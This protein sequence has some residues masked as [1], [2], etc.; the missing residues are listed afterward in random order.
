MSTP[1]EMLDQFARA[2]AAANAVTNDPT[3][4]QVAP[5]STPLSPPT[6]SAGGEIPADAQ[7]TPG[8]G[9]GQGLPG[10]I[11]Q[12][13]QDIPSIV[14]HGLADAANQASKAHLDMIDWLDAHGI[15]KKTDP[16]NPNLN[17]PSGLTEAMIRSRMSEQEKADRIKGQQETKDRTQK[18]QLIPDSYLPKRPQTGAGEMISGIISFTT[19]LVATGAV[20]PEVEGGAIAKA[21]YG[22][23]KG[24]VAQWFTS[25][26]NGRRLA[27]IIGDNLPFAKVVTDYLSSKPGD[28]E[29]EK[30]MKASVEGMGLGLAQEA[31]VAGLKYAKINRLW[32]DAAGPAKDA[33]N[34]ERQKAITAIQDALKKQG[35][36][37]THQNVDGSWTVKAIE[38]PKPKMVKKT[39]IGPDGKPQVVNAVDNGT[40]LKNPVTAT[41]DATDARP[42]VKNGGGPI[43]DAERR[44]AGTPK[45]TIFRS[46]DGEII[47]N[48]RVQ[49]DRRNYVRGP[50]AQAP[51]DATKWVTNTEGKRVEISAPNEPTSHPVTLTESEQFPYTYDIV[52]PKDGSIGKINTAP[53]PDGGNAIR[54]GSV[55]LSNNAYKGQGFGSSAYQQLADDVLSKGKTL[56][57]DTLVS[58][59]AAHMYESL[60]RKGYKVEKNPDAVQNDGSWSVPGRTDPVFKVTEGPAEGSAVTKLP[61]ERR[62]TN[63]PEATPE[64][65]AQAGFGTKAEAP[66]DSMKWMTGRRGNRIEVSAPVAE[67]PPPAKGTVRFYHGGGDTSTGGGRWVSEDPNYA[68]GYADKGPGTNVHYIDIPEDSPLLKKTFDDSFEGSPKSSYVHFEVPEDMAKNFKPVPSVTPAGAAEAATAPTAP[69]EAPLRF[70][71]QAEAESYAASLNY[72][73]QENQQLLTRPTTEVTP[74]AASALH[75]QIK[76]LISA[77]NPW[78]SQSTGI[79]F[80]LGKIDTG[81]ETK[82]ALE[83]VSQILGKQLD[84]ARGGAVLTDKQL[85]QAMSDFF[86]V[87][88]GDVDKIIADLERADVKPNDMVIRM[89]AGKVMLDQ[90][91]PQVMKWS[92]LLD[93]NPDNPVAAQWM[94]KKLQDL[95]RIAEV[96]KGRITSGARTTASGRLKMSELNESLAGT[97]VKE[98]VS[99]ADLLAKKFLV[100][101]PSMNPDQL[102]AFARKINMTGGDPATLLE[103]MRLI[104]NTSDANLKQPGWVDKLNFI[105]TAGVLSGPRTTARN[106]LGNTIA[107]TATPAERY[108]TGMWGHIT[109]QFGK[110][111]RAN[112]SAIRQEGF[113]LATGYFTNLQDSIKA[114]AKA[115]ANDAPIIESG[116]LTNEI[117]NPFQGYLGTA[118]GLPSRAL[119]SQ[120]EFFKNMAYRSF[121]RAKALREAA[122]RG[123]V[124]EEAADFVAKKM[125]DSMANGVALNNNA[126]AFAQN[127]TFTNPLKAGSVG[128][129]LARFTNNHPLF[130]FAALPFVKTPTNI[131]LWTWD[132]TPG[133]A[134]ALKSNREALMAGGERAAEVMA[135]QST[136]AVVWVAGIFLAANGMI[137]GSG[138]KDPVQQKLWRDA[139]NVPYSI[140][141]F[142]HRIPFADADPLLTPFGIL[143]DAAT[144]SGE[145]QAHH[146]DNIVMAFTTALSRNLASKSYL[147]GLTDFMNAAFSG[148]THTLNEWM[149]NRVGSF[150]PALAK[151]LNPDDTMRE[152]RTYMDHI[153]GNIPGLSQTLPPRVTFFGDP[154]MKAPFT[155]DLPLNPFTPSPFVKDTHIED[156]LLKLGRDFSYPSHNYPGTDVDMTSRDW[157]VKGNLTAYDRMLQLMANPGDGAPSLKEVLGQIVDADGW[158]ELSPGVPGIDQG[159]TQFDLINKHVQDY[160]TIAMKKV[161]QE[162]PALADAVE[163]SKVTKKV[164]HKGG[165]AALDAVMEYFNDSN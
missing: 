140:G 121:I 149:K 57:S 104:Q 28:T 41:L 53:S 98:T 96:T 148:K 107:L 153:I 31:L 106:M 5:P 93:S 83:A 26:P 126:L 112:N 40:G 8:Q 131:I 136:G 62:V 145:L 165:Q 79:H 123:M 75:A 99:E 151:Q 38:Q 134:F 156:K 162:F 81:E 45:Q 44:A 141:A 61:T 158:D 42:K 164:A 105:W 50:K 157:G 27:N 85:V 159:G 18:G 109:N 34:A 128:A 13:M 84:E 21:A 82:A 113:D 71:T 11:G 120:D 25:D 119:M 35:V 125:E 74:E 114:A 47:P 115:F 143:A 97:T 56:E 37:D 14:S 100:A 80:N 64:E 17:S 144:A 48:E 77:D 4:N 32:T 68:K 103:M 6:P 152:M 111:V 94:A 1:Q 127:A 86:G 124:G 102:Q 138:P 51:A 43:T 72:A 129:D 147:Y 135:R 33:L 118:V 20:A 49:A 73:H 39:V 29:M 132:R 12:T 154:V 19:G 69:L 150:V 66:A 139:G 2:H 163:K 52:H 95:V 70:E 130:R 78:L 67:L 46:P 16:N 142:G 23:V 91:T 58:D 155:G 30:R 10:Y 3:S 87:H 36:V 54:V 89:N 117:Q 55:Q 122:E 90:V 101:L 92:K 22:A 133:I 65:A 63:Y 59:E 15:V 76:D 146:E 88:G 60:E 108:M 110:G 160:R 7:I 24:G 161:Y 137:T 9:W 116:N